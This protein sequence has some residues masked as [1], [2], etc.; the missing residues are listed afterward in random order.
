MRLVKVVYAATASLPDDERFG[1]TNQMR[2][3]AV[4]VPSNIA[5]GAARGS[6]KDLNRFLRIARGS[7]AELDTQFWLC[8]DL[9]Y[10]DYSEQTRDAIYELIAKLNKLIKRNEDITDERHR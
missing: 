2:R 4:S 7:L 1:L 8:K 6:K 3:A 5:E 10:F 9:A